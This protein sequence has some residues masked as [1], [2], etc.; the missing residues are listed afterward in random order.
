MDIKLFA[1]TFL[2]L[3]GMLPAQNIFNGNG[4]PS[5]YIVN[6]PAVV[7]GSL[8]F[9]LG[10]PTA[11]GGLAVLSLSGGVGPTFA[12][13]I[14]LVGIDVLNPFYITQLFF[15]DQNGDASLTIPLP[16]G[17]GNAA[18]APFF[19]NALAI[20]AGL[21]FSITKTVRIEWAD[22]DA[23]EQ[24]GFMSTPRQLHTA[25]ALGSGPR[26]NYSQVLITGGATGS[27]II[28]SPM[29]TTEMYDLLNRSVTP[30]PNLSL[31][32]A[33]HQALRLEDGR[34]LVTGGVTTGG[35]V[36]ASCEVFNPDLLLFETSPAMSSPRAGHTLTLLNDGRVLATGGVSD[37][38][39]AAVNFIGVLNTAQAT[40]EIFDPQTNTWSA[41]PNMAAKRFGH[42]ATKMFDGRVAVVS[43]IR[44]GSTG[45]NPWGSSQGG[46]VP[47][48]TGS[49]ELFDPTTDTFVPAQSLPGF[50][51]PARGFHG[52]SVLAGGS[53]LITGGFIAGGQ[54]GEAIAASGAALWN[55]FDWT[56]APALPGTAALHTQV[57]FRGGALV[58]GGFTGDLLELVPS[59]NNV[60]HMGTT[61]S[62]L[63]PL[64][65]GGPG[66]VEQ[67][68]AGHSCTPL[69]DGTFLVYGG[70]VWP[71]TLSDGWVYTPQQ[72]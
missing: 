49:V 50:L 40:A 60:M 47:V 16:P 59:G 28:P 27:I 56:V 71:A 66:F 30:L 41:L 23:W 4:V 57:P 33:G 70:G 51:I 36:T 21:T 54:N 38:Q 14:G 3:A 2:G 31:P 5:A 10:S 61:V 17:V 67:P 29:A 13:A 32:R 12:P 68:R 58:Q 7:G 11:P 18:Q 43:G 35:V 22:P 52:A 26:D 72:Q 64:G 9:E 65:V 6:S 24:V 34:I 63:A 37:W 25:T 46:Q 44:G 1:T 62:S 19:A 53:L 15:L 8:E 45:S 55:G 42:S 39:N 48:Y 69:Y 20:E